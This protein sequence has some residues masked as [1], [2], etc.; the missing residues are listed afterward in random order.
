MS[1]KYNFP[2]DCDLTF[3]DRMFFLLQRITLFY[4]KS[5]NEQIDNAINMSKI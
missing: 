2:K 1:P 5:I 4:L 3:I